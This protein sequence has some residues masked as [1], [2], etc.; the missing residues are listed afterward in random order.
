MARHRIPAQALRNFISILAGFLIGGLNNLVVLPWAFE[1]HLED[2]GLVRLAA[3]WGTLIGPLL[4]FSAPAAINR[5]SPRF[6]ASDELPQLHGSLLHPLLF[7]LVFM[8]LLPSLLVPE[9]VAHLLGLEGQETQAIRP[10]ACLAGIQ[11]LQVYFAAFL[12]SRLKT[13]LATFINE[14]LVKLGYMS[15]A[16]ALGLGALG[17]HQF[18]PA[19]VG[20]YAIALT[21]LVSQA[22]ANRY[23][24]D[25]KGFRS[26]SIRRELLTY[27]A[28]MILGSG[29]W[30][31]L[32]QIDV[33]MV[34]RLMGLEW[35][36][37]FTIAAFIGTVTAIPMRSFMRLALPL[38]STALNKED[39]PEVWRITRLSHR[40]MLLGGGWILT[41]IWVSTPQIDLL[42]KPEFK[43]LGVVIGTI[44]LFKVI[45]ASAL[46]STLLI[47]QSAHYRSMIGLNWMMVALAIPLN[48]LFIPEAGLGM[49]LHGAALATLLALSCSIVLKQWVVWRKW[50]TFIPRRNSLLIIAVLAVPALLLH[51]WNPA[52]GAVLTLAVKG[53]IVTGWV[54][55]AT[56]IFKLLPEGVKPLAKRWPA[57]ERWT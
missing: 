29:A 56:L 26:L 32:A 53:I 10:I 38:I 44:G 42:M 3:A 22:L 7:S 47:G 34:G 30:V 19:F 9:A 35:V 48:F 40:S 2:W 46:G 12:S 43:G 16:V 4:A 11:A 45:N 50:G 31:I 55:A 36:P 28:S 18:L 49:G 27:G 15:L 23:R 25:I 52:W 20:V 5:F 13:S 39:M 57:L 14:T 51:P 24:I 6:K 33:I 17:L 54:G 41:S 1:G 21:L 8:V 37:A